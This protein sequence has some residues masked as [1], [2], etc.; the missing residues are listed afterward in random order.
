MKWSNG[1]KMLG[2]SSMGQY[3][4]PGT[5]KFE[6][7]LNSQIYVDKSNLII[8]T[9]ERIRTENRFICVSRPRRFGKTM[10]LNMLAS[11]YGMNGGSAKL[12]DTLNISKHESYEEH[13]NQ[14]Y[15]VKI[16]MQ[17]F[18]SETSTVAEMLAKLTKKIGEEIMEMAPHIRYKEPSNLM[19]V[20]TDLHLDT[21]IPLVIL[22]DEWDCLF[23]EYKDDLDSQKMYSDFLRN[24][25]KDRPFVG[26]AYMTGILPI[27]KYGSHSALNMFEEYSMVEPS[28]FINYFGFTEEEV[29]GLVSTFSSNMNE[30][31]HWYNGYFKD[32]GTPIYNPK[33]VTSSLLR[34]RFSSYWNNTETY[35]ALK[36][37]IERNYDGLREKVTHLLTGASIKINPNHFSNDMTT[38]ESADDVLTLLVH[39][40]YLTFNIEEKT[41]RIPNEEV[42]EEFVTSIE[43]LKWENVLNALDQSDKLLQA[44][45]HKES[46][47][48]AKGIEKVHEENTSILAYNDENSLS[49]V[50]SLA[51]YGAKE[52]YMIIRE[53]PSGKGYADLVFIPRKKYQD[54]PAMIVEL[55]WDKSVV[56]A[57][58]QIKERNYIA[59]L[60]EY[61]GNVLLVGIN[62]DKD[63]KNHQCI[64]ETHHYA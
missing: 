33:S 40:G 52:Y 26:L 60:E 4:N 14:Y 43:S 53:L 8:Q 5:E 42:K 7:S 59:A 37:Y 46:D 21:K 34:K 63:N 12:F 17:E 24:L 55:K 25:L 39:L 57:I 11:Y 48:V 35:E 23:R 18:L 6:M 30:M 9:N 58:A 50:I 10:A 41:V 45:W 22:I 27:K 3:I 56:G 64:I 15:V 44:I 62:Y 54:K 13:L 20:F 16:I 47:V 2:G 51:L 38:F 1:F 19:Q 28:Q 49:C 29:E 36:V 61:K 31:E 32:L